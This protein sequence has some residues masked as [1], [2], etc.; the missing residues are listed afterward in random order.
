MNIPW[1]IKERLKAVKS[2]QKGRKRA[3]RKDQ[4]N[5]QCRPELA[6]GRKGRVSQDV[7]RMPAWIKHREL[8]KPQAFY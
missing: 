2:E 7:G 8:C 3:I 4:G 5:A 6:L 1:E